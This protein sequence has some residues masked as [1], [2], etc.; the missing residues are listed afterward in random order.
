MYQAIALP[1]LLAMH[2]YI[3][4]V[5]PFEILATISLKVFSPK[6]FLIIFIFRVFVYKYLIILVL[7]TSRPKTQTQA[8]IYI[9]IHVTI[10]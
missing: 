10:P 7:V 4:H 1:E 8:W 6:L 9:C 3:Q 2:G 5:G